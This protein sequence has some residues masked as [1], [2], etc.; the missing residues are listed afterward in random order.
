MTTINLMDLFG[1]PQAKLKGKPT[2]EYFEKYKHRLDIMLAC[3]Q[4][5]ADNY[6]QQPL[7]RRV[8]AAPASFLRVAILAR[9]DKKYDVEVAAC[10]LWYSIIYDYKAQDVDW[11]M[12]DKGPTS[13][14]ILARLPKARELR[15]KA[16]DK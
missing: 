5:E 6:W 13:K 1:I 16:R 12:V 14:A 15:N 4:A 9:K 2:H 7:G 3:A 10:E 8:C 11:A